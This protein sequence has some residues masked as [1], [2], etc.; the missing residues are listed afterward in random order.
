MSSNKH[1]S[2]RRRRCLT[3]SQCRPGWGQHPAPAPG[4]N[5]HPD[6]SAEAFDQAWQLLKQ[7]TSRVSATPESWVR[8][9]PPTPLST[10]HPSAAK[11]PDSSASYTAT[12]STTGAPLLNLYAKVAAPDACWSNRPDAVSVVVVHRDRTK[13]P[14]RLGE[15]THQEQPVS[16]HFNFRSVH[17]EGHVGWIRIHK[18]T[19]STGQSSLAR[20]EE[21]PTRPRQSGCRRN[22]ALPSRQ[23]RF[24][25]C[26]RKSLLPRTR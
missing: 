17:L 3:T 5:C 4:Y 13:L 16:R 7:T 18:H 23:G 19:S 21:H 15:G 2:R 24:G 1:A 6:N 8:L 11:S 14:N 25:T 10:P 9:N 12:S 26:I 20:S 22:R